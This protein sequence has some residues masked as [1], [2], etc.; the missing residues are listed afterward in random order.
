MVTIEAN[1]AHTLAISPLMRCTS[2]LWL[3]VRKNQ[4]TTPMQT[5]IPT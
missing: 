2:R 1:P 5:A 3:L 4:I